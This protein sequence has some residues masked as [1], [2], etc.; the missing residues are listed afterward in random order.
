MVPVFFWGGRME[1]RNNT[2]L[3]LKHILIPGVYKIRHALQP[4]GAG[5]SPYPQRE[6]KPGDRS[7]SAGWS[8]MTLFCKF[9][10][11]ET[12]LLGND[13]S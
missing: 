10:E 13:P 6:S 3:I 11:K 9:S 7:K 1:T 2:I 12:R 5:N 4:G 8:L